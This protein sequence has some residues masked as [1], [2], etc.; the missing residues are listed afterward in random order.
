MKALYII[1]LIIALVAVVLSIKTLK[2]G[3]AILNMAITGTL[4]GGTHD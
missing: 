2:E 1:T 3:D 4:D